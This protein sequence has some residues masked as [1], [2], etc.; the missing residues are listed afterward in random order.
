MT[1]NERTVE[2]NIVLESEAKSAILYEGNAFVKAGPGARKTELL[3]Q[4]ASYLFRS[5]RC[6]SP[7]NILAI[8]FKTDSADNIKERVLQR[9]GKQDSERFISITFD[10][11]AK[12]I[13]D[14]FYKTLPEKLRPTR[15]YEIALSEKSKNLF[16]ELFHYS[17]RSYK[18]KEA[19]EIDLDSIEDQYDKYRLFNYM[20]KGKEKSYLTFQMIV[21]LALFIVRH[22]KY[23]KQIIQSAFPFV[24]VDEFQ[25]TTSL[26]Y[27]FLCECFIRSSTIVTA[28][29]DEKQQIMLWAGA[30]RKIFLKFKKDFKAREFFLKENHRSAQ[31]I[32]KLQKLMYKKLDRKIDPQSVVSMNQR[33]RR[34]VLLQTETPQKEAKIVGNEILKEIKNGISP[35]DIAVLVKQQPDLYTGVIQE[36]L[37]KK[38]I[39]VRIEAD[40]T[41]TLSEPIIKIIIAIISAAVQDINGSDW[42]QLILELAQIF[43]VDLDNIKKETM[44]MQKFS[45]FIDNDLL[46]LIISVEKTDLNY[47]TDIIDSIINFLTLER[48]RS[49]YTQYINMKFLSEIKTLFIDQLISSAL[50]VNES[51]FEKKWKTIIAN[52]LGKNSIPVLTIHKSKGLEY[53]TVFFI[54]LED[55]A[56]WNFEEETDADRKAFFVAISRAK[57][58]L[59]FSF[60]R[61]RYIKG[62]LTSQT[63]TKIDEFYKLFENSG[64]VN[65]ITD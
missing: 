21:K 44:L 59:W 58:K 32:L 28:V 52:Y 24:F 18:L 10:A 37:S 23:V 11:F 25:D 62:K 40:Y 49:R 15:D 33:E 9:V 42:E 38:G 29:G 13:V 56:F 50:Q 2:D 27:D 64:I 36:Y 54:G 14:R 8:S 3:A 22:N 61:N 55:S 4:K 6:P 47:Y 48:I 7:Y 43:K 45:W 35:S 53:N 5:N 51:N 1:K 46:P 30:D 63:K 12:L 60:C 16:E 41:Q 34:I 65:Y 26:Q 19:L 20:V 39:R 31:K 57:E 17:P